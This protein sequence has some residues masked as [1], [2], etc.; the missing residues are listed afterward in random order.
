MKLHKKFYKPFKE[1]PFAQFEAQITPFL[2]KFL[3]I[4]TF[5]HS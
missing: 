5:S 4:P 2:P 1:V 3:M